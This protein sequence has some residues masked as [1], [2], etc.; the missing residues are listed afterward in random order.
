[1]VQLKTRRRAGLVRNRAICWPSTVQSVMA[2]RAT[3][4]KTAATSAKAARLASAA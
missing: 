1:M 3:T 2:G 4:Q